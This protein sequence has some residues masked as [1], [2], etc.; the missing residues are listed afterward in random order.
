MNNIRITT[1]PSQLNAQFHWLEITRGKIIS[2]EFGLIR[3]TLRVKSNTFIEL[4][5]T[6]LKKWAVQH[7]KL[8]HQIQ[9][10]FCKSNTFIELIGTRLKNEQFNIESWTNKFNWILIQL[11]S[12]IAGDWTH[13]SWILFD[14]VNVTCEIKYL[15]ETRLKMSSSTLK[16]LSVYFNERAIFISKWNIYL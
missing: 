4:I 10:N 2:V 7:W 12:N 1:C 6:R 11:C 15:I 3:W 9:L 13:F 14:L 5:W 8:D 16:V